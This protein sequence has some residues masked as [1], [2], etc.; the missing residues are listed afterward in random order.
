MDRPR[1][2]YKCWKCKQE[3]SR[4]VFYRHSQRNG[5]T[6]TEFIAPPSEALHDPT[7]SATISLSRLAP[8]EN[9]HGINTVDGFEIDNE[10]ELVY[11]SDAAV[12]SEEEELDSDFQV[13][14]LSDSD[15]EMNGNESLRNVESCNESR[16]AAIKKAP[17]AY[18]MSLFLNYFQLKFRI[19]DRGMQ[20]LLLWLSTLL[21]LLSS[22]VQNKEEIRNVTDS[23]PSTLYEMRKTLTL[24]TFEQYIM[25]P[26]C[27]S[28]CGNAENLLLPCNCTCIAFPK[29]PHLSRRKPC[30]TPVYKTVKICETMKLVPRKTYIYNNLLDSL[31]TLCLRRGMLQKCA[32][33]KSNSSMGKYIDVYDGAMW[34][35]FMFV[36]GRPFLDLPY[37]LGFMLNVDWF[38]PYDHVQYSVGVIYLIILNLPRAERYKI[39][40][41]IIVGCIPGPREPCNMNSYLQPLVD[42]LLKLWKGITVRLP[43]S[44]EVVIRGALLGVSCDLPATRKICGFS[45]HS[46]TMGC[47]KC[48]KKFPC[49]AFGEK[50]DYSGF[51]RDQW[52]H[53]DM[54]QHLNAVKCVQ[55]SLTPTQMDAA[56]K[57]WS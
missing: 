28:L 44:N 39:E 15:D 33:W 22:I 14:V 54:S 53:R 41:I 50:N 5:C 19:P 49:L 36:D 37:N 24:K 52:Q 8:S 38:Q 9:L 11:D 31:K 40:N 1:K 42:D 45:G 6:V 13:E 3:L 18:T 27:D 23:F 34:K 16:D 46:A 30:E 21:T 43:S 48:L 26:K 35:R 2:R 10:T 29:H 32:K 25:C 47:S 12:S 55:S 20:L 56:V 17:Y 7:T 4:S 51:E 57:Q